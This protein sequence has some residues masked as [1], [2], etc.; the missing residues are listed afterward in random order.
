MHPPWGLA[1][2]FADGGETAARFLARELEATEYDAT[3]LDIIVVFWMMRQR[4]TFNASSDPALME[5]LERKVASLHGAMRENGE[6]YLQ[7][8][9]DGPAARR[10]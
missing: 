8:I 2:P 4:D 1:A 9:R 5:L 7:E 3:V 10:K 6:T